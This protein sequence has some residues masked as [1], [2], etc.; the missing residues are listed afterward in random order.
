MSLFDPLLSSTWKCEVKPEFSKLPVMSP[1]NSEPFI[2]SPHSPG[3]EESLPDEQPVAPD[4]F[5][6]GFETSKWEIWAYY[7]YYIGNAG[8]TLFQ[9][10]PTAF[11][12]LLSQAAGESGLLRFAGS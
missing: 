5:I 7:T 2:R 10:A 9:F 8:L 3:E 12:N 6:E 11:Q 4:Q 1:K